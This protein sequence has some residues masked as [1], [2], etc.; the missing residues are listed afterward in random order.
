MISPCPQI[1]PS[2]LLLN[3][4]EQQT[5]PLEGLQ[6]NKLVLWSETEG[7]GFTSSTGKLCTEGNCRVSP[8]VGQR[9]ILLE[10]VTFSS[11]WWT[12][13]AS[14]V[15]RAQ[16]LRRCW[17]LCAV[18]IAFG[19]APW[20]VTCLLIPHSQPHCQA[21]WKSS[22]PNWSLSPSPP[23]LRCPLSSAQNPP[24]SRMTHVVRWPCCLPWPAVPYVTG[25]RKGVEQC[26]EHWTWSQVVSVWSLAP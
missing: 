4:K 12:R 24:G 9:S 5:W 2:L 25:F 7:A 22:S 8:G 23:P 18:A 13:W 14:E 16:N 3:L 11:M 1:I 26:R 19:S 20:V 6:E 10:I 17:L 21:L 15:P